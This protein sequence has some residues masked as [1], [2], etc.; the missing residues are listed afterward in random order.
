MKDTTAEGG[1]DEL[2]GEVQKMLALAHV[3]KASGVI[4][5]HVQSIPDVT[6]LRLSVQAE[7]LALRKQGAKESQVLHPILYKRVRDAMAL[8]SVPNR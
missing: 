3:T 8:R 6:Q 2:L 7:V 5:H 1:D 4:L